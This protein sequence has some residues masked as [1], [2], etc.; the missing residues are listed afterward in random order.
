M[1]QHFEFGKAEKTVFSVQH[2]KNKDK[3]Q[4]SGKWGKRK[5]IFET[6]TYLLLGENSAFMVTEVAAV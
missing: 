3:S 4:G 5:I 1:S 2:V 6:K